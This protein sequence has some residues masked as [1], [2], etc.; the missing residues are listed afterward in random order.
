MSKKME[1]G[2]ITSIVHHH[3]D[4]SALWINIDFGDSGQ[5]FGGLILDPEY[6]SRFL[7]D[8]CGT[9]NLLPSQTD[10]LVGQECIVYRC[11]GFYNDHIEAI[12]KRTAGARLFSLTNWRKKYWPESNFSP[13]GHRKESLESTI[14]WAE[15]RALEA[16]RDLLNLE[17]N[18]TEW[19]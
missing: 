19:K 4:T 17:K 5:G 18:Y 1:L 12:S 14:R 7:K 11:W 3:R 6:V 16:Q 2:I 9:F 13:I 10:S 15:R 8:L